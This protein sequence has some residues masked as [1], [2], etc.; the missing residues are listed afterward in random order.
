M[1]GYRVSE[2][3]DGKEGLE[4][5]LGLQPHLI[6]MDLGLPKIKVGRPCIS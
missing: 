1:K 5:A 6:L 4:K 2:A 3:G